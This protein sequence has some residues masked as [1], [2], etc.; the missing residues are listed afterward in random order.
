MKIA[1]VKES[2]VPEICFPQRDAG[3]VADEAAS[4]AAPRTLLLL[5]GLGL[6][7]PKSSIRRFVITEKALVGAFSVITNLRICFGWNFL[8]H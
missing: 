1:L 4:E 6:S 5:P 2:K 7:A 3:H 8:R